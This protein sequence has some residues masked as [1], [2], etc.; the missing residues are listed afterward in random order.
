GIAGIV[1]ANG[2]MSSNTSGEGEIR[3]KLIEADIV[4]CM[5]ALPAQLFF[6]TQIPACLWFLRKQK[7]RKNEILFIDARNI[8]FM[9]DRVLREFT[10][11]DTSKIADTYHTWR[12]DEDAPKDKQYKD[13]KGFCKSAK[14]EEVKNN[15][16][17]L[18]PGRYVGTEEAEEDSE[19][20][21]QKFERLTKE[22]FAQMEE[23]KKL[24][25]KI[26]DNLKKVF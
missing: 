23:S 13:I 6:N 20:F 3:K 7:K 17:V 24:D 9:A 18:T 11:K 5:V 12:L 10:D 1:L 21:E 19:P 25:E 14:L 26:K 15:D 4:E 2:S 8:G 16:Y 22:L